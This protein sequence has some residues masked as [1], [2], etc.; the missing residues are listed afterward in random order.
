MSD[1]TKTVPENAAGR[2]YVDEDC[3]DCDL[4]RTTAPRNFARSADGGYSFVS[5]QP[6]TPEQAE[7][8]HQAMFECPAEAIGDLEDPD[9]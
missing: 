5:V 6:L 4:C 2:Y 8:C 1:P 7:E 9:A 3:I